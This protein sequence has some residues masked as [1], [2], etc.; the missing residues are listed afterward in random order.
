M[1]ITWDAAAYEQFAEARAR[2][3]TDLL[4]RVRAEEPALVVD[5]GCG[6][7]GSTRPLAERWPRARVVGVDSSPQMLERARRA[8][9]ESRV[10][11]VEAD[12]TDWEPPGRPDVVVSNAV[13]QWV[14]GHLD[15]IPRWVDALAP[16][17][18]FG[19]HVPGNADAPNHTILR[20][21][22]AELP[23][24]P[25]LTV[26]LLGGRVPGDPVDYA[27]ALHAAGCDIDAWETT[28]LH[29]LDPAGELAHPVLEWMRGTGL[30]PV[31][32]RLPAEREA[33][34]LARYATALAAAY[35]RTPMGVPLP[36]RRVFA[37][38]HRR[39]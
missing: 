11:W 15:L 25:E 29:L 2:P 20:D 28:Y 34:L 9:G 27:A 21:L 19:L 14:P 6:T 22:V 5:L 8:D 39:G 16:G 10:E 30:R 13:L 12:I 31:L 23:E 38:G 33:E 7:G 24:G 26:R 17:G 36:F 1:T 37:V 4:A 3:V 35:P 18:W 32:G